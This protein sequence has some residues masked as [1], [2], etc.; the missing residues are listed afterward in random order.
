MAAGSRDL[1]LARGQSKSPCLKHL[2]VGNFFCGGRGGNQC[3]NSMFIKL[4]P[5]NVYQ[6]VHE[7]RK[8]Q[9]I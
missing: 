7:F 5:D 3:M 2:T 4:C 1:E 9:S 8:D 6:L